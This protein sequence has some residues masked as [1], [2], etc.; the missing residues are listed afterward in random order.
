M[1]SIGQELLNAP[2]P[3]MVRNMGTSI[4]EAQ[5]ALD[6]TSIKIAQMMSGFKQNA[7]GDLGER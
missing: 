2:F 1:S 5:F 6:R 3:E 4:A 7:N